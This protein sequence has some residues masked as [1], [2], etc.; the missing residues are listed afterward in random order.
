M[1]KSVDDYTKWRCCLTKQ[2]IRKISIVV[3]IIA[4]MAILT[5][6]NPDIIPEWIPQ[7][8]RIL[9][10]SNPSVYLHSGEQVLKSMAVSGVGGWFGATGSWFG[11]NNTAMTVPMIQNDF[12]GAFV[13]Y[14]FGG[15]AGLF[16]VIVQIGY[17][18]S[19]FESARILESN[20]V[21]NFQKRRI[22]KITSLIIYGF[23]LMLTIQWLISWSNVLGLLPVM[24]QP[25]TWISQANSHLLFFALPQVVFTLIVSKNLT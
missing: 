17:V 2:K 21:Q 20:D 22:N 1:S 19:L 12:I 23:G 24:G 14:K 3:I 9:V 25:M 5:Y 4:I 10:W 16:L 18:I 13:L 15:L 6:N 11:H 8:D 7:K